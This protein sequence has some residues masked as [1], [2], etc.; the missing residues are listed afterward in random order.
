[1]TTLGRPHSAALS[2]RNGNALPAHSPHSCHADALAPPGIGSLHTL[3]LPPGTLLTSFMPGWY[4]PA[5]PKQGLGTGSRTCDWVI[6]REKGKEPLLSWMFYKSPVAWDLMRSWRNVQV[7]LRLLVGRQK[8]ANSLG[9]WGLRQLYWRVLSIVKF[10]KNK[11]RILI[12]IVSILEDTNI[13]LFLPFL[14]LT[15]F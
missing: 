9:C 14:L 10:Y 15:L 5:H 13:K 6:G 12:L 7:S 4:P 11:T 2:H 3:S 8:D 1:M